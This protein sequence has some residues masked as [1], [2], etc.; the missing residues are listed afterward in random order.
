GDARQGLAESSGIAQAALEQPELP[1]PVVDR[2]DSE[3]EGDRQRLRLRRLEPPRPEPKQRLDLAARLRNLQLPDQRRSVR[4]LDLQPQP[5][6]HLA[7]RAQP[8]AKL[9][10]EA[11]QQEEQRLERVYLV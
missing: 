4:E 5:L 9:V 2:R 7:G 8:Q 6:R 3:A 1:L 10:E 11:A